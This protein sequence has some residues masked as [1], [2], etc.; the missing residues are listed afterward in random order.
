[1]NRLGLYQECL[2]EPD[3]KYFLIE[4][5]REFTS[6][7]FFVG[8]CHHQN[9]TASDFYYIAESVKQYIGPTF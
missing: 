5:V 2:Q 6:E 9:C 4:G 1:M 7:H 8:V 3:E